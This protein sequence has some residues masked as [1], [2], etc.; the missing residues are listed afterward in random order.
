MKWIK[1]PT[2][3]K[4]ENGIV[5]GPEDV[6]QDSITYISRVLEDGAASFKVAV[7]VNGQIVYARFLTYEDAEVW[8]TKLRTD[9]GIIT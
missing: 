8:R 7:C 1:L 3:F 2:Y 6:D 5:L 4:D 9:L